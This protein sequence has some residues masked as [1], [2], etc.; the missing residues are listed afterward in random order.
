VAPLCLRP[1]YAEQPASLLGPAMQFV[2]PSQPWRDAQVAAIGGQGTQGSPGFL[3]LPN[4]ELSLTQKSLCGNRRRVDRQE[5]VR[6]LQ[7]FHESVLGQK[8]RCENAES[9]GVAALA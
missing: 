7:R 6:D 8:A 9:R 1:G 3:V 2:P 5:T 4:L